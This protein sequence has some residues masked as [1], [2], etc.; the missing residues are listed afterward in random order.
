M[1]VMLDTDTAIALIRGRPTSARDRYRETHAEGHEV[2]LS[3]ISV[4][5][6]WYGVNRSRDVH[7]NTER[8]A[9]FLSG[10]ITIADFNELDAARAAQIRAELAAAGT[11][12]GPYDLLIAGQA[13]RAGHTL[14][15]ANGREFDRVKYL[16]VEKWIAS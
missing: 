13:A 2:W 4:F 14:V 10:P 3:S 8:L 15:S 12:I 11:P 1:A 5:E 9:D 16:Q 6:L 7:E